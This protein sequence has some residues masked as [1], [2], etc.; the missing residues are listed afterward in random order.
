LK[1]SASNITG[2]VNSTSGIRVVASRADFSELSQQI[3]DAILFLAQNL[4]AVKSLTSYSGVD[5]AVLDF[6]AENHRSSWTSFTFPARLLLLAGSAGVSLCLSIY[7]ED[8]KT[9]PAL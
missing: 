1:Y 5:D 3:D 9:E 2:K 7:P 6:G 8:E 4:E